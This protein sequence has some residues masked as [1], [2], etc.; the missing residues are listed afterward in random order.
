MPTPV[1]QR[2]HSAP[3]LGQNID[4][5]MPVEMPANPINNAEQQVQSTVAGPS[6]PKVTFFDVVT[7]AMHVLSANGPQQTRLEN[8]INQRVNKIDKF[9]ILIKKGVTFIKDKCPSLKNNEGFIG[10]TLNF[11]GDVLHRFVSATK[12]TAPILLAASPFLATA[13][14]PVLTGGLVVAGVLFAVAFI[15]PDDVHRASNTNDILPA[16]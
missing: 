8:K 1:L 5:N 11:V 10:K 12:V 13:S 9:S 3:L 2:S 14:A 7:E 4:V 16:V 15:S 6:K